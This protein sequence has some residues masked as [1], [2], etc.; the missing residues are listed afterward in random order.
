M[1]FDEL[2][3]AY[4]SL[5]TEVE[6]LYCKE[7]TWRFYRIK[8]TSSILRVDSKENV[9]AYKCYLQAPSEKE[10]KQINFQNL[11]I[12]MKSGIF[13]LPKSEGTV[14]LSIQQARAAPSLKEIFPNRTFEDSG[15]YGAVVFE[16]D[17]CIKYE[18]STLTK[19]TE[20]SNIYD[21][22]LRQV[23]D[24]CLSYDSNEIKCL[25][26]KDTKHLCPTYVV[27]TLRMPKAERFRIYFNQPD[28]VAQDLTNKIWSIA[29]KYLFLDM[30]PD[31]TVLYN[32]IK[33]IDFDYRFILASPKTYFN[34]AYMSYL[35]IM[36]LYM[37]N[38]ENIQQFFLLHWSF[39]ALK[40]KDYT[41]EQCKKDAELIKDSRAAEDLNEH[42]RHYGSINKKSSQNIKDTLPDFVRELQ[43]GLYS[44]LK[45][46]IVKFQNVQLRF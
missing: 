38:T 13:F 37:W 18:V 28:V 1:I 12:L 44:N 36:Q 33:F 32:G 3:K 20:D 14:W 10:W 6:R 17:V 30:K 46:F 24:A 16:G 5:L 2:A 41:P 23:P 40:L 35:F 39:T 7:K 29:E 45:N 8:G 9:Y 31:N 25:T 19:A 15:S 22:L 43:T 42:L 26:P 34:F 4:D 21:E 11:K 27:R